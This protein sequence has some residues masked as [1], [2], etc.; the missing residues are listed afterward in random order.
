MV[1]LRN[2]FL[3]RFIFLYSINCRFGFCFFLV[4]FTFKGNTYGFLAPDVRSVRV[5]P[6]SFGERTHVTAFLLFFSFHKINISNHSV[7]PANLNYIYDI[8]KFCKY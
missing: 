2:F 1:L 5:D 6:F 8:C 7:Q 4:V 3:F